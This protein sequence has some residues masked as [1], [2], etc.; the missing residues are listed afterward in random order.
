MDSANKD[1]LSTFFSTF[2]GVEDAL[3]V[4]ELSVL[5][6]DLKVIRNQLQ[7]AVSP[8]IDPAEKYTRPLIE[9]L[10]QLQ[11]PATLIG[12]WDYQTSSNI[13]DLECIVPDVISL[14]LRLCDTPV[15]RAFG[16]DLAQNVMARHMRSLYRGIASPRVP[17]C[18][19]SF[20]VLIALASLN[21]TVSGELLQMFNFQAE[22]FSRTARYR[23]TKKG[24]NPYQYQYGNHIQQRCISSTHFFSSDLRTMY[25]RFVLAFLTHGDTFTKK[26]LIA[27]KNVLQFVFNHVDEDAYLLLEEILKTL[28]TN[29]IS[30]YNIPRHVKLS[31]FTPSNLSKLADLYDRK[32]PEPIS[33]TE[34]RAVADLVHD[35]LLSICTVPDVGVC[36][37]T[38]GW[39]PALSNT[40]EQASARYQ[41]QQNTCLG[42]FIQSLQPSEDLLQQE[43]L[44]KIFKECPDLIQPYWQHVPLTYEPRL[45]TKWLGNMAFMQKTIQLETPSMHFLDTESYPTMPPPVKTMLA[46]ILPPAFARTT[47]TKALQ[48]PHPLV[49]YMSTNILAAAFQKYD[50]VL[51]RIHHVAQHLKQVE[52]RQAQHHQI[53]QPQEDDCPPS[54]R[55]ARAADSLRE[56]FRGALPEVSAL[57]A[58][59]A[60]LFSASSL[61]AS[62]DLVTQR[63]LLQIAVVRLLDY[64]QTHVPV[65]FME[66]A[67]DPSHLIPVDILDTSPSV[68][69]HLLRFLS[70][71]PDFQWSGRT[72]AKSLSHITTLLTLYLRTTHASIRKLT[73]E[74]VVKTLADTHMFRHDP[75]EA[76]LWLQALPSVYTSDEDQ[77]T[78]LRFLDACFI[79]FGRAEYRYIERTAEL[80]KSTTLAKEDQWPLAHTLL[81]HMTDQSSYPFSPMLSVVL[82]QLPFVQSNKHVIG[83]YVCR[84]LPLLFS[85]Q[86]VPFY[87]QA[88]FHQLED[89]LASQAVACPTTLLNASSWDIPLMLA[90]VK[91]IIGLTDVTVTI[92]HQP[93]SSTV[94]VLQEMDTHGSSAAHNWFALLQETSVLLVSG[95]LE[96]IV[97]KCKQLDFE[98]LDPLVAYIAERHPASGS[99]FDLP[100]MQ[101]EDQ[102]GVHQLLS[103]LP[104][105]ILF[106]NARTASVPIERLLPALKEAMQRLSSYDLRCALNLCLQQLTGVSSCDVDTKNTPLLTL[107]LHL[108]QYALTAA[109]SNDSPWPGDALSI[110]DLIFSHPVIQ[111]M[112][113]R[114]ESLLAASDAQL[115]DT[116]WLRIV[117]SFIGIFSD[118]SRG[119]ALLDRLVQSQPLKE[120]LH[121]LFITLVKV[122]QTRGPVPSDA[123]LLLTSP[124]M[125]AKCSSADLLSLLDLPSSENQTDRLAQQQLLRS[126]AKDVL[127]T[128]INGQPLSVDLSLLDLVCIERNIPIIEELKAQPPLNITASWIA[129]IDLAAAKTRDSITEQAEFLKWAIEH[130]LARLGKCAVL[131]EE[132]VLD[133]LSAIVEKDTFML[134][135]TTVDKDLARDFILNTI[136][137]HLDDAAVLR[138]T[139]KVVKGIYADYTRMEP[140]ETYM[141]RILQHEKYQELTTPLDIRMWESPTSADSTKREAVLALLHTLNTIQPQV[142]AK[143]HGLLDRLLISYSATTSPSDRLI[144]AMLRS[145]EKHG[146]KSVLAK[147]LVWGPGSDEARE[148][149]AQSGRLFSETTVSMET[150]ASIDRKMMRKTLLAMPRPQSSS[151][152]VTYDPTFFLPLFANLIAAGK[153]E[154]RRFIEVDGLGLVIASLSSLNELTRKIGFQILDQF[155]ALL[156]VARFKGM[157]P[158]KFL[159]DALKNAVD[160]K[161]EPAPP[162]IPPAVCLCVAQCCSILLLPNHFLLPHIAKWV[163]FKPSLDLN[164]VPMYTALF[165]STSKSSKQERLWLLEILSTS[166]QTMD[167]YRMYSRHRI[168]DQLTSFYQSTLADDQSKPLIRDIVAQAISIP[169]VALRLIQHNGLLAWIQQVLVMSTLLPDEQKHWHDIIHQLDQITKQSDLPER[170]VT[171]L[172]Q[173]VQLLQDLV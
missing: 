5:V 135:W 118:G 29:L 26:Q 171:M 31:V 18:M 139:T 83:Q 19:S 10:Q 82:E 136:L 70:H 59:H 14:F 76:M 113:A 57:T 130:I 84:L 159:M 49:R 154:S 108:I 11:D 25:V 129:L 119:Q 50:H 86:H 3:K 101:M 157:L 121:E 38:I 81:W 150:L 146:V 95:N 6:K 20:R 90:Q 145:C 28:K 63:R 71:L 104:F 8:S 30:D 68:L 123:L 17:Q 43:L 45:S 87:I 167:D 56:E 151:T 168:W 61:S 52:V 114:V 32:E 162:R 96:Q 33:P 138:F 103:E 62:P 41:Q 85:K 109:D 75:D 131:P 106:H 98:H 163:T 22:G 107:C 125:I 48:H 173:Q 102:S 161:D 44:L 92:P 120:D 27:K 169:P 13:Q 21:T 15:L 127:H 153:L 79:R 117:V 64:Y 73:G 1:L 100:I 67:I 172:S 105:H 46:N 143:N 77:D 122:L 111:D 110:K 140:I 53:S 147:M 170:V 132:N 126:C 164:Y 141:R 165:N 7:H 16:S 137:D 156:E 166:I 39:Y 4:K 9:C 142:L 158:V 91:S 12:L 37:R 155:Y 133:A 54:Q 51:Q 69:V 72:A 23:Q 80:L 148:S 94:L 74:L 97:A 88:V 35:F 66:S 160:R 60:A 47:S 152:V 116:E 128:M 93:I 42:K 34:T 40:Q 134:D 89:A 115:L 99:L 58:M 24:N 149:H 144:L 36:F 65:S 2:K 112:D 55:W 78:L 124:A